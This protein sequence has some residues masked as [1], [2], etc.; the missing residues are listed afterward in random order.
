[1]SH[2]KREEVIEAH[3]IPYADL[4]GDRSGSREFSLCALGQPFAYYMNSRTCDGRPGCAV[5]WLRGDSYGDQRT[6]R[7]K[8]SEAEQADA[9]ACGQ[10]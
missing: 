2:Y 10:L 8:V 3:K 9:S 4:D 6:D 5:I 7:E 1:M